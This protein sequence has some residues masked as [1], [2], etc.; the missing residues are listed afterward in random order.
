MSELAINKI[1]K[2]CES[3]DIKVMVVDSDLAKAGFMFRGG[4]IRIA[5]RID[6]TGTQVQLE[7]SDFA[8]VTGD[9]YD[10][11][12]LTLNELSNQYDDVNFELDADHGDVIMT[13]DAAV[14]ADFCGE[15]CYEIMIRMTKI[16]EAVM[17]ALMKVIWPQ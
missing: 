2:Y 3:K 10:N 14:R 5:C 15:D 12:R 1:E 4:A 6:E 13:A 8:K 9:K 11:M 16:A 17:P 7:G